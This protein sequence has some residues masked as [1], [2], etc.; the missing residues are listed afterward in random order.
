[1]TTEQIKV[2]IQRILA[3]VRRNNE[4]VQNKIDAL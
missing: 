3:D 2:E 4:S 1:M